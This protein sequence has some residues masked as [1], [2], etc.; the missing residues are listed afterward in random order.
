MIIQKIG[1]HYR[2]LYR[3]TKRI[4]MLNSSIISSV[5]LKQWL[6]P[7]LL[8]LLGGL[9]FLMQDSL[10]VP[11]QFDRQMIAQGE[12]WRLFTGNLFH[13]NSWHLVFNLAGLLM[14]SQLFGRLIS[15]LHFILFTLLNSTAVGGLLYLFC[16]EIELYVGLSGYLH[17]LFVLG[18]LLEI[19]QGRQSSYLL[20]AAV[21]A[22]IGWEAY[23]GSSEQMSMMINATVA[24]EAHLFGAS[25]ALPL[26]ACYCMFNRKTPLTK[27]DNI[28]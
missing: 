12:F 19:Q 22:K 4:K 3:F 17:G 8:T 10:L 13:T 14:L 6:M 16:P 21:I 11:L 7:T 24:T 28:I 2:L 5:L 18:C 20:L 23:Y 25:A 1:I 26:F 15:P 27:Q 9:L